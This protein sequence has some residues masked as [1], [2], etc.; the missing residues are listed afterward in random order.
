MAAERASDVSG[1]VATITGERS[2]D[3][4]IAVTSSRTMVIS[5]CA[6]NAVVIV[7]EKR[8]RS[9]ASAAPAG[10]RLASAA[11]ITTDPSRRISSFS[12]PT[13]LSSLS[14]R[15]EFEQTSS[16]R[17]SVL[18]TAV[19]R[20]GRISYSVTGTPWA[21]ACQAASDPAKPP[22]TTLITFLLC[23]ALFRGDCLLSQ[24]LCGSLD[25]L[26]AACIVAVL[27]VAEDL[28]A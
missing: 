4:G 6:D 8:S 26:C 20:A 3:S 18:C 17:R 1:P 19:G 24:G 28:P 16:A 5:G 10:T 21:A 9:T 7:S 15:K 11:R 14:P 27:V 13:A 25:Q 22:P 23:Y 2:L 12:R